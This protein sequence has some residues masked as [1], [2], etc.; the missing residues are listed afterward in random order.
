MKAPYPHFPKNL[1]GGGA[2]GCVAA[3][4]NSFKSCRAVPSERPEDALSLSLAGSSSLVPV[5]TPDQSFS[6]DV[7]YEHL[8]H[9]KPRHDFV[10]P[11]TS[12]SSLRG[13]FVILAVNIGLNDITLK[14]GEQVRTTQPSCPEVQ[15]CSEVV[16]PTFTSP[17]RPRWRRTP[18]A[19]CLGLPQ[20]VS[21]A[22]TATPVSSGVSAVPVMLCGAV[23]AT[24]K[25]LEL[26]L[27]FSSAW[28][29]S[30]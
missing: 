16:H 9:A 21:A 12:A 26:E 10:S 23:A 18:R 8:L 27:S 17:L 2:A 6:G 5:N 11:H 24:G 28:C 25:C 15:V 30:C 29:V 20:L 1:D 3:R 14:P 13:T 22:R 4:P 19:A 7:I